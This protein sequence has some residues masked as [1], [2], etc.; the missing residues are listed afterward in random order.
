MA[1]VTIPAEVERRVRQAARNRCG[2]CL[3]EQQYLLARLTIEHIKP[4]SQFQVNDPHMHDEENLW[5]SCHS[6]NGHKSDKTF[7][8]DPSTKALVPIFN[9]R[10]QEWKEHFKWSQ[11]GLTVIGL[12]DVGRAAVSALKLDSDPEAL[13]VR[14]NWIS[15]GWHPPTA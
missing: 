5:L 13:I 9:P 14:A 6:C 15:A 12:T 3:S 11:D 1:R 8:V 10:T 7:A 2:Y 4:R